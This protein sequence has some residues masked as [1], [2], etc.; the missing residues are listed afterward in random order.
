MIFRRLRRAVAL[1]IALALCAVRFALL[2]LK[3]PV[4]LEQRALWTQQAARGVLDGVG[5]HCKVSGTPATR[6]LI[7][8]NHL[9]YL[10][11]LILSAAVPCCFVAKSEIEKWPFFGWAARMGGTLFIDRSSLASAV[12]V[13]GQIGERLSLPIPI[14]FFPEGTTSDGTFL[15][16]FRPRFFEPAVETASPVTVAALRYVLEDGTPESELCWV[17]DDA[18]LPH[19]WKVL[20][21]SSFWAEVRFGSTRV[22]TDRREASSQTHNEVKALRAQSAAETHISAI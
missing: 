14:L 10:D 16:R 22:Y 9:S 7:V 19:L 20:G 6:G 17:G 2:R 8:A 4:S 15:L 1:G 12:E 3:G 11:I 13:A 18:F 5:I 21:V